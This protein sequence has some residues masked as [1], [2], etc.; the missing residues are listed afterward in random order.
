MLDWSLRVFDT[1][2]MF[3]VGCID[4]LFFKSKIG[5][6]DNIDIEKYDVIRYVTRMEMNNK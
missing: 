2:S 5:S 1:V 4:T 6:L 3:I